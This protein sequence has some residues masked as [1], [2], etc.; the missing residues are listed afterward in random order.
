MLRRVDWN[1]VFDLAVTR[2]DTSLL[3]VPVVW[4]VK[5]IIDISANGSVRLT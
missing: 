4:T 5:P 3:P 2:L 1:L